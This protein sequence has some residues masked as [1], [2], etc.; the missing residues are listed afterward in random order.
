MCKIYLLEIG[1]CLDWEELCLPTL[2]KVYCF[3]KSPFCFP[4]ELHHSI[5]DISGNWIFIFMFSFST[6]SF[7]FI[8]HDL[9][10]VLLLKMLDW[11]LHIKIRV[12]ITLWLHEYV[13]FRFLKHS[14]NI[15]FVPYLPG[16]LKIVISIFSSWDYCLMSIC[17]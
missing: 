13:L 15:F 16:S 14:D 17:L 7:V 10:F 3:S 1:F 5:L 8:S 6:F 2:E 12:L 4:L 11:V 9:F